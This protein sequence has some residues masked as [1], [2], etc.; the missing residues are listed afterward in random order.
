MYTFVV[1][2]S[3]SKVAILRA[4]AQR[5]E[6]IN[7]V[8]YELEFVIKELELVENVV[9]SIAWCLFNLDYAIEF[10]GRVPS[11]QMMDINVSCSCKFYPETLCLS[12]IA[13]GWTR[14]QRSAYRS[15]HLDTQKIEARLVND[16]DKSVLNSTGTH[17]VAWFVSRVVDTSGYPHDAFVGIWEIGVP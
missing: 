8:F 10:I 15:P 11:G 17:F 13:R 6:S 9:F 1:V 5:T 2:Q 4:P 3:E 16:R 12:S 7:I 14:V